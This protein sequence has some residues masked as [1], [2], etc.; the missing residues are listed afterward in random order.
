MVN[1]KSLFWLISFSFFLFGFYFFRFQT[2]KI[3][4]PETAENVVLEGILA[5]EPKI[6]GQSV[7]FNFQGV[8][9]R[10]RAYPELDYGDYLVISGQLLPTMQMNFPQ[11]EKKE[12]NQGIFPLSVLSKTRD[13]FVAKINQFLPEPQASLLAGILLG[14]DRM[15]E[16]FKKD[17]RTTGTIHTVV[18]SGQNVALIAGFF[19]SLAGLI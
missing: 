6:S 5:S 17:L 16:D 18:V 8:R 9:I 19:L 7:Y 1:F 2:T 11:I 4:P 12:S 10:T 3:I 15:P 13:M 14:M